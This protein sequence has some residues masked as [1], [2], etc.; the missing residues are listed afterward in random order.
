MHEIKTQQEIDHGS[1]ALL[2]CDGY[3]APRE[4]AMQVENP[5]VHEL[6]GLLEFAYFQFLRIGC[7]Q[8]NRML[9]TSPIQ[10][11]QGSVFNY[12]DFGLG[13]HNSPLVVK[14]RW[15][16]SNATL[17]AESSC[18]TTTEHALSDQDASSRSKVSG[19]PSNGWDGSIR[20]ETKRVF[21]IPALLPP[22]TQSKRKTH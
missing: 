17:I 13:F 11:D 16:W 14:T 7:L 22:T 9:L 15:P 3:F 18:G 6:R 20:S 2:D 5:V 12:I 4:S 10:P 8:S 19:K 1:L 21:R